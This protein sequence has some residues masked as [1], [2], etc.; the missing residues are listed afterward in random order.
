M[1]L[2]F[3]GRE[4]RRSICAP[5]DGL[6]CRWIDFVFVFQEQEI[7]VDHIAGEWAECFGFYCISAVYT[8][9]IDITLRGSD[10]VGADTS[11]YGVSIVGHNDFYLTPIIE[12]KTDDIV[13][14]PLSTI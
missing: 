1:D 13:A 9:C 8:G 5:N 7:Y 6:R 2:T 10:V 11:G 14:V 4:K 12:I 3:D